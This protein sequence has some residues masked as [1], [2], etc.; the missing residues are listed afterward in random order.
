MS[1]RG[2]EFMHGC[3]SGFVSQHTEASFCQ[4]QCVKQSREEIEQ[5]DVILLFVNAFVSVSVCLCV[6][7][8]YPLLLIVGLY[9]SQHSCSAEGTDARRTVGNGT[10]DMRNNL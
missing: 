3:A 2:Q 9:H 7:V 1:E 10:R 4:N 8:C 5:R 6:C